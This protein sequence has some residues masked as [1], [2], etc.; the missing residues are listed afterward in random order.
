MNQSDLYRLTTHL[1]TIIHH[2]ENKDHD[3]ALQATRKTVRELQM[4]L[5]LSECRGMGLEAH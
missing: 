2:L 5:I 1:Q 3:K 4:L